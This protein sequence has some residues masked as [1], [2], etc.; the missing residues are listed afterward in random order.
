MKKFILLF[1]IAGSL[2]FAACNNTQ[3]SEEEIDSL[4]QKHADSL[5]N[6]A[7]GD[8]TI[9]DSLIVDSIMVDSQA[10]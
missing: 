10:R 9:V 8:T 5:L 6:A 4:N 2:G 3:R 1:A 7:I